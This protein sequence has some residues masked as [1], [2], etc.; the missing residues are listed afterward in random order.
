M[1]RHFRI[2]PAIGSTR[3]GNSPDGFFVGP[4]QPGNP[5]NWGG[6]Q[7][8]S[9][10]DEQGRIK[11]QAARFRVFEYPEDGSAPKEVKIGPDLVNIEWRVHVAN[12]KAS[13]FT[14]DG[15]HGAEDAYVARAQRPATD[16]Q[17]DDPPRLN[18]RNPLVP[19]ADLNL[20]PGEQLISKR[21]PPRAV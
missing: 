5:G 14:F 9:F 2:H 20:D 17:K 3:V 21:T 8:N 19:A 7:F 13:F 4:E 18:R 6:Q 16:P 12:K 10:R 11:R 15:Q 1:P